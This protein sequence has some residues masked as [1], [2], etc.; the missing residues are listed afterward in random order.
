MNFGKNNTEVNGK[1]MIDTGFVIGNGTSRLSYDFRQN[2]LDGIFYGCNAIHRDVS[3][4]YI[5]ITQRKHLAEA[6]SWN[7]D[8]KSKIFTTSALASQMRNPNLNLI[9]E[10]QHHSSTMNSG[11][12]AMLI[13]A[14]NH[15]QVFVFGIDFY[16]SDNEYINTV[17][18]NTDNYPQED[19]PNDKLAMAKCAQEIGNLTRYH[20]ECN[21]I[22]V[23]NTY[24]LPGVL[25]INDNV[26]G[27]TYDQ[28]D[29][30]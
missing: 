24:E 8:T 5:A 14:Y 26:T 23:N 17:Y 29:F 16:M 2:F 20:S 6:I 10:P 21:F 12:G 15:S 28:L 25:E 19:T 18:V 13:A 11:V 3:C 30:T 7:L 1:K 27:I 22:F 4:Q 9:P